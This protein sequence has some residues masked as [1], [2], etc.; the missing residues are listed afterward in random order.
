MFNGRTLSPSENNGVQIDPVSVLKIGN[1]T[2]KHSGEYK[3]VWLKNTFQAI[4]SDK[5]IRC[6]AQNEVNEADD[7]I[8]VDILGITL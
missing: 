4:F 3:Y 6:V 1:L 2:E 8:F 5:F 7:N